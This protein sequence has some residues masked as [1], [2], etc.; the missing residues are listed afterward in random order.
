MSFA[1][2]V[3]NGALHDRVTAATAPRAAALGAKATARAALVAQAAADGAL[4]LSAAQ[5][6]RLLGDAHALRELRQQV[7]RRQA[8]PAWWQG[9]AQVGAV[10][11]VVPAEGSW[12]EGGR[13]A[14]VDP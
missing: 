1:E 9:R 7:L 10:P 11:R 4:A 12:T 13:V 5:R 2:T 8:H 3:R 6:H 14:V